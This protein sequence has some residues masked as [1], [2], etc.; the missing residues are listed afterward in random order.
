MFALA[1]GLSSLIVFLLFVMIDLAIRFVYFANPK[2]KSAKPTEQPPVAVILPLRGSDPFLKRCLTSLANQEYPDYAVKIIVDNPDDPSLKVVQ[3]VL[4]ETG[5]QVISYEFLNT[6]T[7]TCSLKN[8]ALKQ[9]YEGLPKECE[10]VIHIDSDANPHSKWIADLASGFKDPKVGIV[11]GTRWFAPQEQTIP[12][13]IRHVWNAGAILQ[14]QRYQIGW[15]GAFAMKRELIKE[16]KLHELWEST[17]FEDTH[18]SQVIKD[19]GYRVLTIPEITMMNEESISWKDCRKFISR[20]VLG[21]KLYHKAWPL[22]CGHSLLAFAVLISSILFCIVALI[23]RDWSN[24]VMVGGC[25]LIY[26]SVQAILIWYGEWIMS[27]WQRSIGRS[28]IR[29][30]SWKLLPCVLLTLIVYPICILDASKIKKVKWRGITYQIAKS[31]KIKRTNY[32]PFVGSD[33]NSQHSL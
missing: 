25:L 26:F 16:A 19:L 5:S 6:F 20:Q 12:N 9:A 31:G 8:C 30:S 21:V 2:S 32:E 24:A 7:D 18:G 15:G 29:F 3:D 27:G 33:S 13:L 14:M 4:S 1:V 23:T 22:I 10:V 28:P 11:C 17:L